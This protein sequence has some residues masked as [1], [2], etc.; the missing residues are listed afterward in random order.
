M[1]S[2][3]AFPKA[4]EPMRLGE[5]VVCRGILKSTLNESRK[6]A[7]QSGSTRRKKYSLSKTGLAPAEGL[8]PVRVADGY[9]R[10]A[11]DNLQVQAK[12]PV[13]DVVK[14]ILQPIG[15][16]CVATKA[17][18]LGP[19]RHP[20]FAAVPHIV[21][22]EIF[23]ELRDKVGPLWPRSYQAHFPSND[24]DQLRQLVEAKPAQYCAYRCTPG[25]I[26]GRPSRIAFRLAGASHSAEFQ[27]SK[28]LPMLPNPLLPEENGSRR[29]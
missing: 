10:S 23:F 17:I 2:A 5:V 11:S 24:I 1:L 26:P 13:A 29:A 6:T 20:D 22:I 9:H 16:R 8:V 21:F 3:I 28:V 18:D 4:I 27:Q 19:S 12:T 25:I 14:I 7:Q 15:D